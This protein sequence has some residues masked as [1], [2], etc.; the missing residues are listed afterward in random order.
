MALIVSLIGGLLG[1]SIFMMLLEAIRRNLHQFKSEPKNDLTSPDF[2]VD[3]VVTPIN[4]DYLR[5]G[6]I[7]A[8]RR[9]FIPSFVAA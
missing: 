5:N 9:N 7:Y 4:Y 3:L 6:V 2:K 1:F 8:A